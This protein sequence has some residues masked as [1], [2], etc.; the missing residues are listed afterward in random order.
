MAKVKQM[1]TDFYSFF[2]LLLFLP[3]QSFLLFFLAFSSLILF[4]SLS[5]SF[6]IPSLNPKPVRIESEH[7]RTKNTTLNKQTKT[8][9]DNK[10]QRLERETVST[11][12][13]KHQSKKKSFLMKQQEN[14]GYTETLETNIYENSEQSC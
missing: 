6:F 8:S 4:S 5:F 2:L 12:W 11:L 10:F 14:V 1:L 7:S 9:E 13:Y 3:L